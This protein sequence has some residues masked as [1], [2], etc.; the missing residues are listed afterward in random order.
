LTTLL[1]AFA[2]LF[3]VI[4][5]SFTFNLP[6]LET[7]LG[8][9]IFLFVGGTLSW[10]NES[11]RRSRAAERLERVRWQQTLLGIGDA[12]IST[13]EKGEIEF[14]NA[15]AEKLT[16]YATDETIG[17]PLEKVFRIVNEDTRAT[18]DNPVTRV[19]AT[20]RI[21]GLA[22]HT[23]LINR[24]N[25]DI[26]IEDSGAPVRN[27]AG[28]IAGTVLI[29]RDISE[30]RRAERERDRFFKLAPDMLAV[31][32]VDGIFKRVSPSWT[33]RLGWSE[34]D[35]TTRPWLEFVHPDDRAAS[36]EQDC[37]SR[38][39]KKDGSWSWLSWRS[40]TYPAE[41]LIYCAATDITH[42]KLSE[43]ALVDTNRRLALLADNAND[44]LTKDEPREFLKLLAGRVAECCGLEACLSYWVDD[45][46]KRMHLAFW[47]G[48]PDDM[49]AQVEWLDYGQGVCGRVGRD[50]ACIWAD[51]IQ[52]SEDPS[53]E[54]VRSFGIKAYCCH[55]LIAGGKLLGT[56][57]FG[58]RTPRKFSE[59]DLEVMRAVS[60]QVALALERLRMFK[61]LRD[62]NQRLGSAN[63]ELE[64][65]AYVASHDL[66]EPLRMVNIYTQ[67][68]LRRYADTY[69]EDAKEYGGIVRKGVLRMEEL[70]RDLLAYSRMVH[71]EGHSADVTSLAESLAESVS[72]LR[73]RINETGAKVMVSDELGVVHADKSQCSQ[74]FQNLLANAL[75]YRRPDVAPR[76]HIT[77]ERRNGHVIV[78]VRDNG[79]GF[80]QKHAERIFGLF[81]R[82]HRHDEYPG[83]GLG[84]AIAKRI[85]ERHGGR[86]WENGRPGSGADFYF[87][88]P[89][90]P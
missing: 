26:P 66:Q 34:A 79:I 54:F 23:V 84:L 43:E 71:A 1:S 31:A 5:P 78:A 35:L 44:L 38:W 12:V 36:I 76:I 74:I 85:V 33:E 61:A 59:M 62:N 37:E 3:I 20:G 32:G 89:A 82:L 18:V 49:A 42:R 72:I 67:L 21:V 50:R 56:L 90:A 86:M 13:N 51:D 16:G 39:K 7:A 6:N 81:K 68:L 87:T 55:P 52:N 73:S 53:L 60:D 9:V 69:D 48:I 11:L 70:I 77:A 63:R 22:N 46:K 88:L 30:R 27:Q 47:S 8:L 4:P 15:V 29:F 65:F 2:A 83:T 45:E 57:S 17:Q 75:K 24:E 80:D 25:V 28:A 58:T 10:L 14:M 19:L 40:V 41:N 64:E